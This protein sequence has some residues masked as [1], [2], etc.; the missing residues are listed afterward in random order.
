MKK[1]ILT[2]ILIN[3]INI[4]KAQVFN[5][6]SPLLPAITPFNAYLKDTDNFQN[7]FEGTWIYQQGLSR[8]EVQFRKREMILSHP[9]PYQSYEDVLVGEYR[10]TDANG[11]EKVNSLA[12]IIINHPDVYDY[13]LISGAKI[14]NNSYPI[15]T[16]CPAGAERLMISFDEPANDDIGL[17]AYLIIRRVVENG[18][19]KLLAEF[20]NF[21]GAGGL[22]KTDIGSPST[23]TDFSLPYGNYTLIKQ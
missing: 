14:R 2:I 13:N 12:N 6:Y 1:I 9:G 10:Y 21:A 15:C 5:V 19:E 23:F 16:T 22:K 11:V 4:S 7:Q 8:L 18:V 3:F 20:V 17:T